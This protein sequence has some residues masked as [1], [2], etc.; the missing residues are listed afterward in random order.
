MRRSRF[1]KWA[2]TLLGGIA[3]FLAPMPFLFYKYG[4]RI[5]NK[6][7]FAPCTDL[8]A[9]VAGFLKVEGGG[10]GEGATGCCVMIE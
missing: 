3:L 4:S 5:R 10:G 7:S 1:S 8:K 6:S 9:R 2:A